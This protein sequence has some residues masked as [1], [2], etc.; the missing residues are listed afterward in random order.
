M[1]GTRFEDG[2]G[3]EVYKTMGVVV[4]ENTGVMSWRNTEA[5]RMNVCSERRIGQKASIFVVWRGPSKQV[6]CVVREDTE[7]GKG[8]GK[9]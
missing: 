3:K 9:P 5:N 6:L 4:S 7:N 2:E 1:R 8:K